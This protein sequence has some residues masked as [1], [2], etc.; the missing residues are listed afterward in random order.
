VRPEAV[1]PG[2]LPN[3]YL[4]ACCRILRRNVWSIMAKA[5]TEKLGIFGLWTILPRKV[6][7]DERWPVGGMN[8][9][10]LPEKVISLK[11]FFDNIRNLGT[12]G[13]VL[14]FG[15]WIWKKSHVIIFGLECPLFMQTMAI[16]V[17]L[18]ALYLLYF[19][20]RQSHLLCSI[21]VNV[22][23][24]HRVSYYVG[25]RGGSIR[26]MVFFPVLMA[27]FIIVSVLEH[28]LL[29]FFPVATVLLSL[30]F[31]AFTIFHH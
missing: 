18:P 26:Q 22:S 20:A 14:V 7:Q 3:G 13:L 28:L 5:D 25:M 29:L 10:I 30:G 2:E 23:R 17:W 9:F 19:N 21:L 12:A 31:V 15:W 8:D 16:F 11:L 4:R 6:E 1:I 24:I 27:Y